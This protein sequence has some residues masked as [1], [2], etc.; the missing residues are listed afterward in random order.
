MGRC[1]LQPSTTGSGQFVPKRTFRRVAYSLGDLNASRPAANGSIGPIL[2]QNSVLGPTPVF[3]CPLSVVAHLQCEGIATQAENLALGAPRALAL[4]SSGVAPFQNQIGKNLAH[5]HNGVLQQ[6]WP[7]CVIALI[8]AT[9][10]LSR[11]PSVAWNPK[12]QRGL[13]EGCRIAFQDE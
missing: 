10:L 13:A 7:V 11:L 8:S 1:S 6:Y 2:L 12:Q 5:A 3:A 4:A 9:G